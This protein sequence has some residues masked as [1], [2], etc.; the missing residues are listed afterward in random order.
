VRNRVCIFLHGGEGL[1]LLLPLRCASYELWGWHYYRDMAL[2]FALH[3]LLRSS[4]LFIALLCCCLRP[5]EK[6]IVGSG[7][8][9]FLRLWRER[10]MV[11]HGPCCICLSLHARIWLLFWD[12]ACSTG[13]SL[14]K[15]ATV[16]P[17]SLFYLCP[18]PWCVVELRCF[19]TFSHAFV[20]LP[21][22]FLPRS[23]HNCRYRKH[24]QIPRA[25][26]TVLGR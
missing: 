21:H 14:S 22:S 16:L 13:L 11:Y 23:R 25:C 26:C 19:S 12:P 10:C 5:A 2:D 3:G 9:V 17:F 1:L 20:I 24:N 6:W 4:S 8:G 7:A 15:L 18:F